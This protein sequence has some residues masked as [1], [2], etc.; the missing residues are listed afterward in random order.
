MFEG[1]WNNKKKGCLGV[2]L[3][4]MGLAYQYL[5][6]TGAELASLSG[7]VPFENQA[8]PELV[9]GVLKSL[10]PKSSVSFVLAP[11]HYKIVQVDRL[12]V[13]AEEMQRAL[14]FAVKDLVESQP[15]DLVLDYMDQPAALP[16]QNKLFVVCCN[17]GLIQSLVDICEDTGWELKGI[18]IE[19][20]AW[21]ALLPQDDAA[22]LLVTQQG[23][24]EVCL[25][26]AKENSSYFMR[27]LRG[28]SQLSEMNDE[29][30][31]QGLLDNL[32]LEIQRSVDYFESQ[33]RQPPLKEVLLS[34]PSVHLGW[35][36]QKLEEGFPSPIRRLGLQTD[37]NLVQESYLNVAWGGARLTVQGELL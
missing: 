24:E 11:E 34:L 5:D 4:G 28:Y 2:S 12:D 8:L 33:L 30:I 36:C 25:Q 23:N 20:L 21:R 14:T 18:T 32:S 17:K 13:P 1:L 37:I 9:S 22:R 31:A 26:I 3:S 19:E 27:R 35:M 6:A 15:E 10:S 16:G 7:L 29:Q